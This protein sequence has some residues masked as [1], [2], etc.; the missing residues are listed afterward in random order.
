M[1]YYP[2]VKKA[3]GAS[4]KIFEYLDRKPKIPPKG[5]LAPQNLRGH[6]QFKKVMFSYPT[7]ENSPVLKVLFLC[8][9]PVHVFT[10]FIIF[11][12]FKSH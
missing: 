12:T 4:E 9:S 3:I 7:D 10:I 11:I 6:I 2:A 8:L 5:T 1:H